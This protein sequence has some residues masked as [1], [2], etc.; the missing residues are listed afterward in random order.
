MYF[1]FDISGNIFVKREN[2]GY[3]YI[4]F[5]SK[6]A[7][8]CLPSTG[9]TNACLEKDL[10]KKDGEKENYNSMPTWPPP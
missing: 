9:N 4:L 7:F 6:T 10:K 1:E 2:A 8:K 3:G 5:S